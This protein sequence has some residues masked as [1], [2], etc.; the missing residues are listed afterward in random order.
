MCLSNKSFKAKLQD[1]LEAGNQS[2]LLFKC[3][4]NI[5]DENI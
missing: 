3:S 5:S 1:K 4:Q 2:K